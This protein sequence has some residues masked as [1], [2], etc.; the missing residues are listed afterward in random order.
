MKQIQYFSFGPDLGFVLHKVPVK[1]SSHVCSVWVDKA[2]VMAD[3]EWTWHFGSA[4]KTV[5]RNGKAWR[6]LRVYA[7]QYHA[8][9]MA[10]KI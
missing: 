3:A 10:G 9:K 4:E 2:G 8:L 1:G 5:K 7:K 6:A